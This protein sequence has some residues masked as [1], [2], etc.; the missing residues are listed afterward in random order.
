MRSLS[1]ACW[2]YIVALFVPEGIH[3]IWRLPIGKQRLSDD[4]SCTGFLIALRAIQKRQYEDRCV[5]ASYAWSQ[6]HG[7]W[8]LI[9]DQGCCD[10]YHTVISPEPQPTLP[11][12]IEVI[13]P[14]GSQWTPSR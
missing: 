3:P 14:G 8:M 2:K 4:R 1:G 13:D 6:E 7:L 5:I 9:S 12:D 11:A 10:E